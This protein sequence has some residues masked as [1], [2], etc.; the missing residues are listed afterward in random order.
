[1]KPRNALALL[2]LLATPAAAAV[3]TPPPPSAGSFGEVVEVNVVN[4]DVYATDKAG[5]RVTDLKPGDFELLE[6]GKP[7][8]RHQLHARAR[9]RRGRGGRERRR[10]SG[11]RGG[12]RG[13]RGLEPD[14]L[15]G[16]LQHR[17]VPPGAGPAEAA[18]LPRPGA[19][20]G[21]P[22]DGGELRRPWV[23]GPGPLHLQRRRHG[24]GPDG[25]REDVGPWPRDRERATAGLPGDPRSPA[26]RHRQRRERP[27][28]R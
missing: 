7:R 21:R 11:R 9:P 4:V 15:R 2:V 18:G 26:V 19:P 10:R 28:A 5:R 20:A 3:K 17:A 6:D 16:Q 8:G 13:A 24:G 1:M 22:G 14:R 12:R 27:A 25:D 23:H